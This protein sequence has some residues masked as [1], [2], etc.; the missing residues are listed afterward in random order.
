MKIL[1]V[2]DFY[3]PHIGGVEKLFSSLAEELAAIGSPVTYITWRYNRNLPKKETINGVDILRIGAPS[4]LLF[5][6]IALRLITREARKA[7]LIHT[8]TYSS[9]IGAWIASKFTGKKIIITVHEVWGDLWL[10]MPFLSAFEKRFFKLF[11]NW[12]LKL[13][14]DRYVA[15]SD[16]TKRK[17]EETGITAERITRIYNGI[18]YNLPEWKDPGLPFT[19]CFFG[20]AGASKGL[21]ILIVAANKMAEVHP[22][23][24]FKFII[25][26]QLPKVYKQVLST[27][28]SGKL[29]R[30]SSVFSNLPYPE[31]LNELLSSNCVIIPSLCE[32]FGFTAVEASAMEIPIISSGMGSLPEVVSGKIITMKEYNFEGLVEA[33]E[34]AII[35][36]FEN[37]PQKQF[38]IESFVKDHNLLYLECNC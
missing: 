24:R 29:N 13:K 35:D 10:K 17:L 18:D 25:S 3:K 34:A 31:L 15:V 16:F 4:R 30:C 2:T 32:G 37:I 21:D 27:I 6:L 12:L 28:N 9:A 38:T 7:D 14:F 5:S 11:E 33:M 23:I 36:K 20:R 8:S 19:F 1:F 22:E 26:P